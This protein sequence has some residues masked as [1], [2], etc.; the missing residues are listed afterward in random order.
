VA[1]GLMAQTGLFPVLP[2]LYLR[3]YVGCVE[4]FERVPEEVIAYGELLCDFRMNQTL[5]DIGCGT[6]RFASHLLGAPHFFQGEYYGFD[7]HPQAIDWANANIAARHPNVEFK[8][9]DLSNTCYN[10][11][12]KLQAKS[13][14]F[15]YPDNKFDFVFACSVFTHLLPPAT[16]NYLGQIGRV[17]KPGGKALLTI[18]LLDGYPETLTETGQEVWKE[19]LKDLNCGPDWHH[20][21][22][23]S[24]IHE[25]IP[26]AL[27]AYQESAVKSMLH[28]DGGLTL[29]KIHHGGWT[30]RADHLSV[31]DIMIVRK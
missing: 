9:V 22:V 29:E 31:Q 1:G 4:D 17:L 20:H 14:S 26:E 5:L 12:G 6:G 7:I 16:R 11:K 28:K 2:P 15:P 13:F 30:G 27:I 23:Y 10:P 8:C 24:V 18:F 19:F 3:A 21:D 25:D